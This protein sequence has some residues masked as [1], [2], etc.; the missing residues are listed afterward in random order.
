[1]SRCGLIKLDDGECMHAYMVALAL[2]LGVCDLLCREWNLVC[3]MR[4]AWDAIP[5]CYSTDLQVAFKMDY[6]IRERPM[7][8]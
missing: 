3:T 4:H 2:Q 7:T 1:V 5:R 6:V 8:T